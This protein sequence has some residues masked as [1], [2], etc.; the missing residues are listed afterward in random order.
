MKS[1]ILS[2][3]APEI[4]PW[5][6]ASTHKL[7]TARISSK[8]ILIYYL[9]NKQSVHEISRLSTWFW[10]KLN[11]CQWN[12]W[13]SGIPPSHRSIFIASKLILEK[14]RFRNDITF[15][16]SIITWNIRH[17]PLRKLIGRTGSCTCS[18]FQIL[19]RTRNIRNLVAENHPDLLHHS[20]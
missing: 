10:V 20:W 14:K 19:H 6:E 16:S 9:E 1:I 3:A 4:P 17:F 8:W 7:R 13:I 2:S 15:Y 18:K 11:R 12:P 5:H